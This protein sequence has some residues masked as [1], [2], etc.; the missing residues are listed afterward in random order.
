MQKFDCDTHTLASGNSAQKYVEE[1]RVSWGQQQKG[2]VSMGLKTASRGSSLEIAPRLNDEAAGS[3][4]DKVRVLVVAD[5]ARLRDKIRSVLDHHEDIE[6]LGEVA[7]GM[8]AIKKVHELVPDVVHI[9][10]PQLGGVELTS[11]IH[12]EDP[13][14]KI[15]WTLHSNGAAPTKMWVWEPSSRGKPPNIGDAPG[16]MLT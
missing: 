8:E 7:N 10:M 1:P 13:A 6:V 5:H 16:R 3:R 2:G 15:V 12:R 9:A 4:M 14:V 11:L